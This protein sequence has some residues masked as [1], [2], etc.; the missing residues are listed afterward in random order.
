MMFD[1]TYLAGLGDTA[2]GQS[3]LDWL[4][5]GT[6][7]PLRRVLD[8]PGRRQGRNWHSA[9]EVQAP[10]GRLLGFLPFSD[11]EAVANAIDAGLP[12]AARVTALMPS[13]HRPRVHLAIEVGRVTAGNHRA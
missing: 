8:T 9:V 11:S 12:A 6:C 13:R 4:R 3:S 7:L 10:D 2:L 5:V 1:P